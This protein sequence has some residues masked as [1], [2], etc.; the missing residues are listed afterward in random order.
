MGIDLILGV[1][2][3]SGIILLLVLVIIFARS[4]LVSTGNVSIEING[5]SS[6][7]IIVPAGSKLL[8]TLADFPEMIGFHLVKIKKI[9]TINLKNLV[10][11]SCLIPTLGY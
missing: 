7:P 2:S 8:Q 1:A 4:K 9:R 3:F 11:I 10:L 5:D 6:N